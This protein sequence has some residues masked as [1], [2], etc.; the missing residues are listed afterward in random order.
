[1]FLTQQLLLKIENSRLN[2]CKLRS[3][4]G[5]MKLIIFINIITTVCGEYSLL[6]RLY[7]LSNRL[8]Y[9]K[10]SWNVYLEDTTKDIFIKYEPIY[11][12]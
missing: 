2:I 6:N 11:N 8:Y 3:M 7:L 1:M 10:M 9:F 12:R 5:G 4:S